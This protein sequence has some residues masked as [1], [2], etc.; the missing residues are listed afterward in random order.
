[1]SPTTPRIVAWR[2]LMTLIKILGGSIL[3]AVGF[4]LVFW[5]A[6]EDVSEAPGVYCI[7]VLLGGPL[8]MIGLAFYIKGMKEYLQ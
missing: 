7:L 5:P 3:S 2:T 6:V 4:L 8:L 1:M